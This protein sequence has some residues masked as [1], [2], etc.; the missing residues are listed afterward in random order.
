MEV[1]ERFRELDIQY[2]DS[3]S[4]DEV[5]SYMWS[6]MTADEKKK[7]YKK[8]KSFCKQNIKAK[9]EI[10]RLYTHSFKHQ[11]RHEGRLFDG[12]SIQGIQKIIRGFLCKGLTTDLDQNNS[13]PTILKYLCDKHNI[14][15][16]SLTYYIDNRDKILADMNMPRDDA[17]R[18]FLCAV[19]KD[20]LNRKEKN[21][22]FKAFDKEIKIIQN[23]LLNID[24]YKYLKDCIPLDKKYNKNGSAINRLLCKYENEI[25]QTMISVIRNKNIEI[26]SLMFD[27]LMVYGDYYND[28]TLLND[29]KTA[30]NN[31]Y[32]GLN[33]CFSYKEHAED[34]KVPKHFIANDVDNLINKL[35]EDPLYYDNYKIEFEKTHAKIVS[36]SQFIGYNNHTNSYQYYKRQNLLDSYEN[37][38]VKIIKQDSKT[39]D[40]NIVDVPFIQMWLKDSNM[41][42]YDDVEVFPPPLKCPSNIF[43][44]W[45]GFDMEKIEN[46]EKDEDAIE[47]FK[48][49]FKI[50]CNHDEVVTD[51]II[52]WI[53]QMIQYPAIKSGV[54]PT[55]I[56]KQGAGKGSINNLI[57]KLLGVSKTLYTSTPSLN[58]WGKFNGLMTN[59]IF[60][61][62]DE[63]KK[64]EFNGSDDVYKSL[65]TE[66]SIVINQKGQK[67]KIINSFHRFMNT[68]NNGN[69]LYFP[70]DN[71]RDLVTQSSNELI[72]NTEYFIKFYEYLDNV[73]AMK[74]V[75]EYF[76]SIPNLD[77]FRNIKKPKTKYQE[78]MEEESIDPVEL[79]LRDYIKNNYKEEEV[80][81]DKST[82]YLLFNDFIKKYYP[83]HKYSKTNFSKQLIALNVNGIEE[84][85]TSVKRFVEIN[86]GAV[87]KYFKMDKEECM[88][89]VLENQS[90]SDD[91]DSLLY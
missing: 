44:L 52:K 50:M 47:F 82:L 19:N 42:C 70:K 17:K 68:T 2:L 60:V 86:I 38:K 75:F 46:Y 91:D 80:Q 87:M 41:R 21:Q 23:K 43:N 31:K 5:C 16:P 49:H 55:F 72:G 51:Y 81:V 84:R 57:V 7:Y 73:D 29:I 30:V 90:D 25:L 1:V 69:A 40:Y 48:N 62:L 24:E 28:E 83:E 34:I 45:T 64:K 78:D 18:L 13:H 22:F 56:A 61:N 15:C 6:N 33:M 14:P 54:V 20:K 67:Q 59:A 8:I 37:I 4:F 39:D 27:G 63:L 79:W 26:H 76:K 9:Y 74:S 36:Q 53:A 12:S 89:D 66:P 77:K 11:D 58:V 71:R 3:L 35:K 10:K 32:E 88:L 85:R 65:I